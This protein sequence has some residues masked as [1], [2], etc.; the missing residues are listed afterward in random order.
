MGGAASR[1]TADGG[2]VD[3]DAPDGREIVVVSSLTARDVFLV[4]ASVILRHRLAFMAMAAGPV[5]WL[6]GVVTASAEVVRVAT[7]F[8]LLTVGVPAFA[9]LVASYSAY[10]PG[11]AGLYSPAE[12]RFDESGIDVV[13]PDRCARVEWAGLA[14]WRSAAGCYLL[15]VKRARYLVFPRRD[16]PEGERAA[17]EAL[18]IGKLGPRRT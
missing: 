2:P 4:A 16:V 1:G 17:F 7:L 3:S 10:R 9:A 12:W 15:D 8:L 13:Q 11:S 18:L 5:F 6:V 14:S